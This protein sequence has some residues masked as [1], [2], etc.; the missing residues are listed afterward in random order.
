MDSL[1]HF[2]LVVE[3]GS[4]TA[5]A[6]R[7]HLTQPTIS[8]SL[9]R[10]EE[11]LGA[12]LLVRLPRG[13]VPTAA[14][15]ALLP[16]ARAALA[17]VE[18]GTRAVAEVEGLRAGRVTIGGGAT[19]CTA[20]LP[21]VLAAFR[22]RFPEIELR[23]RE[24]FTPRVPEAVAAGQLDLGIV[25]GQG[26][27][28]LEDPLILVAAPGTPADA[29]FVT[30]A[31]GT[32]FRATVERHFPERPIAMELGSI[33]AVKGMVQAGMG[34]ALLSRASCHAE[35]ETGA[36]VALCDKRTPVIRQLGLLHPG[37]ER[38]S[39]AARA[40]RGMVLAAAAQR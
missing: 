15:E 29:P 17:A 22:A 40:L 31:T 9:R 6:H 23:V 25:Q 20:L 8:A 27:P 21:P 12:R 39:P 14:G 28:W 35:L 33:G 34:V 18:A 37:M 26:E 1:H 19:A 13:A 4:F 10:L 16:H 5:A 30:F 32:S 7:A 36:L 2:V 24:V 11:Q 3:E 38:L